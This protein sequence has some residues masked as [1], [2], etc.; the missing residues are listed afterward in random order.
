MPNELPPETA[1][2]LNKFLLDYGK[3]AAESKFFLPSYMEITDGDLA[4]L[5][6]CDPDKLIN[7]VHVS[8]GSASCRNGMALPPGFSALLRMVSAR[9]EGQYDH[10]ERA[11]WV[12]RQPKPAAEP[13][14]WG[15]W[16]KLAKEGERPD[17]VEFGAGEALGQRSEERWTIQGTPDDPWGFVTHYRRKRMLCVYEAL[18]VSSA[19]P[20][21][22]VIWKDGD[23]TVNSMEAGWVPGHYALRGTLWTPA[24]GPEVTAAKAGRDPNGVVAW[25]GGECP[26]DEDAKGYAHR[27]NGVSVPIGTVKD[28]EEWAQYGDAGDLIAYEVTE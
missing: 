7:V 1:R 11:G 19:N 27:P 12:K 20:Y 22:M 17:G 13:E 4:A 8:E 10:Y 24:T 28:S 25:H 26:V 14:E 6:Y 2:R 21:G 3:Q 16:A 18:V 15:P 5:E 23:I 9:G